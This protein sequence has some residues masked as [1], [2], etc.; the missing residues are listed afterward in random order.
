MLSEGF[1]ESLFVDAREVTVNDA[2][3][4]YV[5]TDS[6]SSFFGRDLFFGRRRTYRVLVLAELAS[7]EIHFQHLASKLIQA[8]AIGTEEKSFVRAS[9]I[10]IS[11]SGGIYLHE[12]LNV[13]E[14]RRVSGKLETF[15]KSGL[16]VMR[17]SFAVV[18]ALSGAVC[19]S[20]G[21]KENWMLSEQ[22]RELNAK[23][24]T[25]DRTQWFRAVGRVAGFI[26]QW[27]A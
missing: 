25:M 4:R 24:L 14:N 11:Q 17:N 8:L 10:V 15:G 5:V 18:N 3:L 20:P 27:L 13:P 19:L 9:W 1:R 2:R 16:A 22:L 21:A 6:R 12:A 23:V 7:N 26:A